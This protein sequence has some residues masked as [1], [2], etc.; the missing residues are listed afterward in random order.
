VRLTQRP[1]LFTCSFFIER[2]QRCRFDIDIDIDIK[3]QD[4]GKCDKD[5]SI[6]CLGDALANKTRRQA[7]RSASVHI[8]LSPL[9]SDNHV[10][11]QALRVGHA[12]A[13]ASKARVMWLILNENKQVETM[14]SM[15]DIN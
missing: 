8:Y 7:L 15:R 6:S 12:N 4:G 9:P 1:N 5:A 11:R 3:R 14:W 10:K 2:N 13:F